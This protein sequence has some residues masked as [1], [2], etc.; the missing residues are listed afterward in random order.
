[1]GPL[2]PTI[3]SDEFDLIIALFLGFGFGFILEQAGFSSSK[4]LVGLFYGRNF[5][6]LKVFFTAGITAMVLVLASGHF[7]L[8]DLSL[9]YVNP[10]FLQSAI[11][12]GLIMGGGFIIG[13]FCPGTSIC[14]SAIG[15][16]DA[17]IFVVGSFAGIYLFMEIYPM[18]E[19]MYFA[20]NMGALTIHE[21]LGISSISFALI[22]SAG[23]IGIFVLVTYIESRVNDLP[24]ELPRKSVIR[25]S[26]LGI[27]PFV[28]VAI[29]GFT[30]DTTE[31][32]EAQINDPANLKLAETKS[33]DADKLAFEL[34]NNYYKWNVIDVRSPQEYK[35]WHLPMSIN[36]PLDSMLNREWATYFKQS[37]KKNIFYA[38]ELIEAKKAFVLGGVIGQADKYIL[39]NTAKEFKT[40]FY[41]PKEPNEDAAMDVVNLYNFRVSSAKQMNDLTKSLERFNSKPKPRKVRKVQ[42]GCS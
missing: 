3:I 7:G 10:T 42:G 20:G 6:V 4:N 34:V 8:L 29:A 26:M 27:I 5:V 32:I 40:M 36:I 1:M 23:A 14:A 25:M 21:V 18:I 19:E 41:S 37:Q 13:G 15:K 39:S 16:L 38:D 9:I 33:M 11:I 31:R 2:V 24:F 17:I 12:G 35:A 22:L 28:V 30:P